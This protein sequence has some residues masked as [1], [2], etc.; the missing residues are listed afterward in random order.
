VRPLLVEEQ[1]SG[2]IRMSTGVHN[3]YTD[4]G[5]TYCGWDGH[6][7]CGEMWPCSA[8]RG[9]THTEQGERN[10]TPCPRVDRAYGVCVFVADHVGRCRDRA[11]YYF[12]GNTDLTDV[13]YAVA[14]AIEAHLENHA[15]ESFTPSVLARMAHT[16][17]QTAQTVCRYL[18]EHRY[19]SAGG[20]G[21]WTR[22]GAR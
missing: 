5:V 10:D 13:Q 16:N 19:I 20:N 18:A 6:E 21:A 8:V 3:P 14:D 22:Y 2:G 1:T 15:T 17:T 12:T 11:G 7:G 9:T 4:D